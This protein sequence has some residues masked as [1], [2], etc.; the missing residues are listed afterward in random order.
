MTKPTKKPEPV[1]HAAVQE[2]AQETIS[3]PPRAPRISDMVIYSYPGGPRDHDNPV[4]CPAIVVVVEPEG[5][6]LF[7]I[8]P[9]N[10]TGIVPRVKYGK[11]FGEWHWPIH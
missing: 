4:Q 9:D 3:H 1:K 8:N 2:G 6:S 10:T 11:E 7:V 5:L